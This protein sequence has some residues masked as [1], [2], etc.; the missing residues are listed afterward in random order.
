[1][2]GITVI[3]GSLAPGGGGEFL[4]LVSLE[5]L[6]SQYRNVTL[7][8]PDS[9]EETKN[10]IS[11]LSEQFGISI[12]HNNLNIDTLHLFGF[13]VKSFRNNLRKIIPRQIPHRGTVLSRIDHAILHRSIKR[14]KFSDSNLLISTFNEMPLSEP[15][16][17]YLHTPSI[18]DIYNRSFGE[19]ILN[20]IF[21]LFLRFISGYQVDELNGSEVFTNSNF[22]KNMIEKRYPISPIVL[23]PP[24]SHTEFKPSNS[25]NSWNDREDGFVY[26][27]R[28]SPEKR[29]IETIQ[30][31]DSIIEAGHNIHLH[32]VGGGS[33]DEYCKKVNEMVSD[34]KYVHKEGKL[35]HAEIAQIL[36]MHKYGVSMNYQERFGIAVAEMISAGNIPFV[37]LSGG[38]RE[39]VNDDPHITFSNKEQAI[40]KICR[41][42]NRP[43]SG[44]G[45]QEKLPNIGLNFGKNRYKKEL[46]THIGRIL[47]D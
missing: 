8:T 9:K 31:I 32:I 6:T 1:M 38:Q 35:S 5:Y 46:G 33:D 27:G 10:N 17:Q 45:I 18:Y 34:R 22:T 24:V 13:H 16:I 20:Y 39:I 25:E 44:K 21:S 28:I 15:N 2:T 42:L 37:P 4:C 41:V 11:R 14:Q 23:Y 3:H 43:D 7:M 40:T 29:V 36:N 26:V 12:Q 30:L 47:D 19:N